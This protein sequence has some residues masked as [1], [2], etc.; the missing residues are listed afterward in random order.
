VQAPNGDL[1]ALAEK[2]NDGP[3]D[4]GDHDIV[5]VR[6]TDRGRT[7]SAEQ[8]GWVQR[9]G[10]G[11][12]KGVVQLASGRLVIG[13]RHREDIAADASA[14]LRTPFTPTIAA[15]RGSSAAMWACTPASASSSSSPMA[16]SW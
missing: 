14:A 7:W 13:A 2:R 1:L 11:P 16:G 3:G 8:V 10:C 5:M 15:R 12:G 4:V 6:S 9:Y